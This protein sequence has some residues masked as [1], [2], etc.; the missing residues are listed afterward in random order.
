MIA[1]MA[2]LRVDFWLYSISTRHDCGQWKR[3]VDARRLRE[4]VKIRL[5]VPMVGEND[6]IYL[7]VIAG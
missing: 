5:G 6:T 2:G 7:T 4:G 3:F 1:E